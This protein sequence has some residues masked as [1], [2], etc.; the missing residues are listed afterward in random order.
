MADKIP[1]TESCYYHYSP[2]DKTTL[3]VYTVY[4]KQLIIDQ[5]PSTNS[6]VCPPRFGRTPAGNI[7]I[8]AAILYTGAQPAK[9]PRLFSVLNC[10]KITTTTF[11]VIKETTCSPV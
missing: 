7:L 5:F 11:S 8:S 3:Y 1:A 6:N 9:A 2:T 4:H 10:L